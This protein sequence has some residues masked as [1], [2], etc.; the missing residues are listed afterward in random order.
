M[1]EHGSDTDIAALRHALQHVLADA[2]QQGI[3]HE[4][5]AVVVGARLAITNGTWH[6]LQ[7]V[8]HGLAVKRERVRQIQN[9]AIWKLC[10][11][12][13]FAAALHAYLERVPPPRGR[14]QKP[15]WLHQ[16]PHWGG[17]RNQEDNVVQEH[18]PQEG[19]APC[20]YYGEK[21]GKASCSRE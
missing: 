11:Y 1:R 16:E 18:P 15:P 20:S 12:A 9:R 6:T 17:A 7:E 8:A 2:I 13:A 21:Q 5:E 14:H 19:E 4:R 3:I 10:Q